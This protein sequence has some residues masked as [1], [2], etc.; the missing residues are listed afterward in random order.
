MTL[1]GYSL[2]LL[3]VVIVGAA[4]LLRWVW[5]RPVPMGSLEGK[6]QGSGEAEEAVVTPRALM[7]SEEAT[8]FNM[9]KLAVQDYFIVL[10]K[11]PLISL[12][13]LEEKDEEA[14]KAVLRKI[15]QV[16]FDIVLIHPGTLKAHTVLHFQ[17]P[18][19]ANRMI[20]ERHRLV[21]TL[22]KAAEI[23]RVDLDP[24]T[25][26]STDQIIEL[27]GLSEEE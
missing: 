6:S 2:L 7:S 1:S 9:V 19:P 8:L 23:E 15:Q 27:L 17:R 20:E 16:R 10:A 5:R 26:Y 4:V 21:N 22:L 25:A 13:T 24:G 11:I 18:A 3:L 14:K 12:V